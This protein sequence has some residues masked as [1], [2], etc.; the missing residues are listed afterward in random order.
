ML[1]PRISAALLLLSITSWARS[2]VRSPTKRQSFEFINATQYNSTTGPVEVSISTAGGGRNQTAP[3]LYGWMHED[4]SHSGD[5]GIY[6]EALVNRAFQGSGVSTGSS[7]GIPGTSVLDAEN[8]ILPW[9]PVINGWRGIGDVSLSLTLLHPLSEALPVALELDIPFNATGE[10]GFL[11]E[12]FWGI[13]VRPG[14]Y[15]ASFYI[16]ANKPRNN[17]TLTHIDV[18]LRSNLTSDV[19]STSSISFS[20]YNNISSWEYV[21]YATQLF[22]AAQAPDSNNTFAV[23]FDAAE[24]AGNTYYFSLLSLFPETFN[25]RPNGMRRDLG[26]IIVDLGTKVLRFPGGNNIE[27]LSVAQRWKWNETIGPLTDRK[28]RIGNWGYVN[29]NGLGLLEYLQFCEDGGIEPLLAVYAGFSLDIWGQDGVSF[30]EDRM[31]E[32]LDDI[33]NELE[34]ISGG[35]D[36]P[37]GARRASHGR[38][39]PFSLNYVEIGNEDWFSSTYPYR[40]DYLYNGIKAVYPE[41]TLVSTAFNEN[42]DYN[43]TLP[44][45]S[46]WDT[47]HYEDASF[48]VEGF[49]FY[50]HWQ[51]DTDNPNVTIFV[52]EYSMY[53]IDTPSGYINYSRPPDIHIFYPTL[54]AAIAEG[55]YLLG[56]ERNPNV[57]KMSAYAPSFANLNYEEWTPNLVTFQADYDLTVLSTSYYMQQ[58]FAHHRGVETLP[59]TTVAGTFNPLWWAASVEEGDATVYFK[60]INSGNSSVPLKLD[61]DKPWA[62]VNGTIITSSKLSDFNYVG[63]ATSVSPAPIVDLPVSSW[64]QTTFDWAVPAWSINVLQFAI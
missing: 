42:P 59:T 58:L 11:N 48:F 20:P 43:I 33:L 12:G 13:D 45:G 19:W 44:P 32:V 15:N 23:T 22:N 27:G 40:W 34:Y 25:G 38:A 62:A 51:E 50:D 56:A 30:P 16:K 26:Q 49:D 55:V 47:H 39:E 29:T 10:V 41:L 61:F 1:S 52:G 18:S 21:Q 7:P 2:T 28:G 4:I 24:V 37:Y 53:Q 9:G 31:G 35:T 3:L 5:G 46:M 36:T 54:E 6:G 60:V 17:G 64:N 8:P 63:N 14:T 57:V